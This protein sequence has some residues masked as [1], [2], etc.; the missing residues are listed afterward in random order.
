[1]G[2]ANSLNITQSGLQSFDSSNGVFAGRTI[3]GGTGITVTNGNGVSGNP[4]ISLTGGGVALEHLTGNTGGALN[5]DGSNN[6]NI[7]TANST[8]KVAG[9]G[10]TLTMDYAA[11]TNQNLNLGTSLP[12]LTSGNTNTS[13]GITNL[14]ALTSGLGNTSV[15]N[16]TLQKATSDTF[17]VAFGSGVLSNLVGSAQGRNSAFGTSTLQ[18]VVTGGYNTALGFSAGSN[19]TGSE[20]S[21][22]LIGNTGT[23]S[24]S[25]A[26]HIGTQGSGLGQQNTCF[27]AGIAGVSTSNTTIVTQNSSTNQLGAVSVLTLPNGGTNASSMSTS[28]GIVK[29]DG[30]SLVTSSSA[31]ID[32]SDIQTNIKQPAGMA[33]VTTTVNN[34]T[35]DGT[36]YTV[37]YNSVT[38]PGS[39]QTN[40]FD[41]TTG[42][43]TIPSNGQY[44]LTVTTALTN[45]T[46]SG[47]AV[48]QLI[49]SS[50]LTYTLDS[51]DY[52]Y[53]TCTSSSIILNCTAS[54][55]FNVIVNAGGGSKQVD[56]QGL[57]S[58][59]PQNMFSWCKLC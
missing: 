48:T 17:N 57:I 58:G 7:V 29:Y 25:N 4:T 13:V 23:E 51:N 59:N 32:S 22:I 35:G 3:T 28:D 6:I 9:S 24:E 8:L 43:L 10:S 50:G 30:T 42:T 37:I 1:M 16:G 18:N 33:F 38:S 56:V 26:I 46:L 2:A 45:F 5:P 20:S 27:V 36:P 54:Q 12:A 44:L 21:N 11:D 31:K 34:V 41:T 40:S 55:T 39:D 15:G 49:C 14:D 47:Y 52:S 19:Y 53:S